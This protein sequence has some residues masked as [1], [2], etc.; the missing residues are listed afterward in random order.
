MTS[1]WSIISLRLFTMIGEVLAAI[2]ILG[3][4]FK[5]CDQQN[6]IQ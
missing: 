4:T 5:E 3:E 6:T 2:Q 1:D